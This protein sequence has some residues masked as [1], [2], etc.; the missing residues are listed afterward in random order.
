[1]GHQSS[2]IEKFR[3][4]WPPS[5]EAHRGD[6]LG[7]ARFEIPKLEA[8]RAKAPSLLFDAISTRI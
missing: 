5:K 2:F 6:E 3:H 1:M 4:P 7:L 8:S